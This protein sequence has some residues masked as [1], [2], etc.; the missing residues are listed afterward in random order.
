M[1]VFNLPL[2]IVDIYG[3]SI[4]SWGN[5]CFMTMCESLTLSLISLAL[6]TLEW[7]ERLNLISREGSAINLEKMDQAKNGGANKYGGGTGG[8]GGSVFGLSGKESMIMKAGQ[9]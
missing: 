2:V 3:L 1:L 5:Q 4:L 9:V 8:G 6:M 7:R